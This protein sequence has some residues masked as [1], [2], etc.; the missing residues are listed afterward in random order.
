MASCFSHAEIPI[1]V[2]V[3]NTFIDI[4]EFS[5]DAGG[6]RC[7]SLPPAWREPL[8]W[9][10]ANGSKQPPGGTNSDGAVPPSEASTDAFE[11]CSDDGSSS[12]ETGE[13]PGR[14]TL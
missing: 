9:R 6:R 1:E 4:V 13:T 2:S 10:S 7:Q 5:P 12:A 14:V 3:K 11:E 8:A